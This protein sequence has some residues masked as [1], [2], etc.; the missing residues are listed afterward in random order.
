ML[1]GP[2]LPQL[3]MIAAPVLIVIGLLA[4]GVLLFRWA[5]KR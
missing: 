2:S 1:T 4:F 5:M 3:L